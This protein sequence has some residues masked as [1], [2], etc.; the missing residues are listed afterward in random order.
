MS[1]TKG[2]KNKSNLK[3]EALEI[4][5][6]N[7][8]LISVKEIKKE[9]RGLRRLKLQCRSGTPE[10]IALHRKIK[11]L[12]E[13]LKGVTII[14]KDKE[15]LIEEVYRLDPLTKKMEMDLT[16]YTIKELQKHIDI[17]IKKNNKNEKII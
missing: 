11:E 14:D 2:S 5:K 3:D 10:R 7:I 8:P 12:K 1:R 15:P 13:Q 16:I 17:I 6:D 9:I 4:K